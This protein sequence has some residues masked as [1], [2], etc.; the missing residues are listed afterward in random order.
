L[1]EFDR[2]LKQQFRPLSETP[3]LSGE[4]CMTWVRIDPVRQAAWK[5]DGEVV[6]AQVP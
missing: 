4:P 2:V 1:P 5:R 6:E 3:T